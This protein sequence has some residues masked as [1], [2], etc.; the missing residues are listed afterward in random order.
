VLLLT[1]RSRPGLKRPDAELLQLSELL[2][3]PAGVIGT[4]EEER[5]PE[6]FRRTNPQVSAALPEIWRCLARASPER[7]HETA[8][9]S[10]VLH[11]SNRLEGPCSPPRS[12]AG[13]R[14]RLDEA[15]RPPRGGDTATT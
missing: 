5:L 10:E 12:R 14:I 3:T 11:S 15:E 4:P 9:S 13:A 6:S 2:E 8:K 7:S 1:L